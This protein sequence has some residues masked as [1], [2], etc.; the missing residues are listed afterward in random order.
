[1]EEI[2]EKV[3]GTVEKITYKNNTNGYTVAD[4]R[5]GNSCVTVVGIMP[6]LAQGDVAEFSGKYIIHPSYG[7]QFSVS[8]FERSV[9]ETAAAI[10]RYLSSGIIKGVGPGTANKIVERFGDKALDII[11][12]EPERLALIKGITPEKAQAISKEYNKQ[13]GVRDI[14]LL[15][16]P[17]EASIEAC[18]KIFKAL[19][20]E[21]KSLIKENPYIL[22]DRDIGFS[23]E[24]AEKI[25]YDFGIKPDDPVRLK[26]G[27]IYI[28]KANLMNGHTCLPYDKLISVASAMLE[29]NIDRISYV[30]DTLVAN[31][32]ISSAAFDGVKYIALNNY[33]SAEEYISARLLAIDEHAERL[34]EAD[35]LEIEYAENKRSIK[36]EKIQLEAVCSALENGVFLLTGGP[37]TGKTTTLNA[38]IELLTLRNCSI[39]LAAPTGRAAK[40]MTELTGMEAKTIHRL[41]EVEWDKDDKQRFAKNERNPIECDVLIVDEA[42]MIDTLLFESLLRAL[43]YNA[44]IILVGDVDQLPSVSAGNVF[45]DL[46]ACGRFSTVRLKKVFRQS[47][48]SLIHTNAY[49][50][51]NGEKIDFSNK[52]DDFFIL[53]RHSGDDV[54]N[55]VLEL[56]TG[57][58]FKTYG[59]DSLTDIQVL[60]PSKKLETGTVNLNNIL[61]SYL[62]PLGPNMPQL[63]FKGS[64][65]RKGDKVMQ[66]KNDYDIS[67]DKDD[68]ESGMGVFNGDVGFITEI[69]KRA[70]MLK[71]KF[72]DKIAVYV[73]EQIGELELAYA[74]TVHK[75][76]GSEFNCVI[77]PLFDV[78]SQLKYRNLLYT[79]VTRAKKMLLIVGS[80]EVFEQMAANN[81]KT[82]RYTMLRYLLNENNR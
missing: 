56:C 3:K 17:Y 35:K 2:S 33:I 36:F 41:L 74:I 22:C 30:C 58:L 70:Q 31:L 39:V 45:G 21:A 12:S 69:D 59:F 27:I 13:F 46:I 78:P 43:K 65:L 81:K 8:A 20:S 67:W 37:G 82:L 60:C 38:I 9:P 25:A 26:A 44:R 75:S 47:D 49:A 42:S 71:V 51:I 48:S 52:G 18:V 77:L 19:G 15:L 68:G 7:R 23:F 4:V 57:R 10:F 40:R 66:I 72:D 62:N 61:Q 64:Y 11:Q 55:T 28:L 53:S 50:L 6:F 80:K 14:M 1:M 73:G 29:S 32:E 24:K 76:Q 34:A 79:A 5:I 54:C 16:S 63:T